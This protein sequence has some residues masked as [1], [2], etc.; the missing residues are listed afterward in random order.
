MIQP[1]P[2]PPLVDQPS[3]NPTRKWTAARIAELAVTL[4]GVA[5]IVIPDIDLS[6]DDM[7]KIAGGIGLLVTVAGGIAGWLTRNRAVTP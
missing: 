6:P 5:V 4:I 2:L 3:I 1:Q 7:E